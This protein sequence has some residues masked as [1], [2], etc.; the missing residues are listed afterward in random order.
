[1]L[2]ILSNLQSDYDKSKTH[3]SQK[4][5]FLRS[6]TTQSAG[7][8]ISIGWATA[9]GFLLAITL[10]IGSSSVLPI[11]AA[12]SA[13][14][15]SIP[16]GYSSEVIQVKFREGTT[17]NSLGEPLPQNLRNS[18]TNIIRLFSL[19]EEKLNEIRNRGINHSAK[20]LPNLNSWFQ[21]TLKPGT[22]ADK[23]IQLLRSLD[24][25][26]I[27]E[28]APLPAPL[29]AITPDFTGNQGYLN[30]ATNGIE[31]RYAWTFPGGN[32]S[33]VIIYDLEY[34]WNQTHEDLSKAAGVPLLLAPG[35]ASVDPFNDDNHGTAVLGE[36]VADNDAKGVTG[37]AWGAGI[38]LAPANTTSGYNPA[39][40]ILLAVQA[41][42]PGDVILIEQQTDVCNLPPDPVLGRSYG[43][44]EWVSSVYEAIEVAVNNGFVVVEAAGNGGVNLDQ[45]ACQGRFDR[46]VRDSGAII[47]GAGGSPASGQDRERLDFSSYGSRVD[48][49]GWGNGVMTTGYGDFYI[50]PDDPDNSNTWYTDS[51]SGTSSASPIIAGAVANLQGI[52][53]NR[54]DEPFRPNQIRTLLVET[55]SPQL[56]NTLEHIGPRP[57]LRRAIGQRFF[58]TLYFPI[59]FNHF[60]TAPDLVVDCICGDALNPHIMP[61]GSGNCPAPTSAI[62]VTIRNQG[63]APVT[64]SFWVDIYL[65]PVPAPSG[66]NQIWDDGRAPYGLAWGVPEAALPLEPGETLTLT[67]RPD[68]PY[69][70]RSR[71]LLPFTSLTNA[72]IYAQV[73]S[74]N[75]N[76]TY[77]GVL[78]THEV[79]GG[80]YNN[81]LGGVTTVTLTAT[82]LDPAS[83]Q[84]EPSGN[85]PPRP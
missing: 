14:A 44:A 67:T 6:A 79:N 69:L 49:Q 30:E 53:L 51:F 47:V 38:G 43:P 37:I 72:A 60:T 42:S 70:V 34:S 77:G 62:E 25:V 81:I 5:G 36:L 54:L 28:P 85:L 4:F 73:D 33:G 29:P 2:H 65:N 41:G 32:G 15:G 55:G 12:S 45:P 82:T 21:I 75:L 3:L 71:S 23:F 59:I 10:I 83:T 52:A 20:N 22:D 63:A 31:A 40:A 61:H 13:P 64:T 74:V 46:T 76:T 7:H 68:D 84:A 1:M 56:G 24:S 19:P 27:A 35:D 78:E 39:N 17:V 50:D 58:H 11:Q 80:T 48:L 18:T 57:N 66:V 26:E 8:P 9:L 16:L